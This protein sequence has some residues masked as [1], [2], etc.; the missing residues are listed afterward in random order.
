MRPAAA[1]LAAHV[2]AGAGGYAYASDGS[3]YSA[4]TVVVKLG[5]FV[6]GDIIGCCVDF[7][8]NRIWWSKNGIWFNGDPVSGVGGTAFAAGTYYPAFSADNTGVGTGQFA[9]V[10]G[11]DGLHP[12]WSGAVDTYLFPNILAWARARMAE[13]WP[14]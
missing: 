3:V 5:A 4:G 7:A 14:N 8:L 2:G 6:T 10:Y 11:G 9:T 12:L 1:S 13:L